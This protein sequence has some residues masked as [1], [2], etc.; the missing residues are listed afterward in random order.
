MSN[1]AVIKLAG[2]QFLVKAG[3][4]F[5]V[6]RVEGEIGSNIETLVIMSTDGEKL[7]MNEG[8]VEV[9]LKDNKRDKK[10]KIVKFRAK[11]RYR[12]AA[13]HRQNISM[14]EV[15]SVNG[16]TKVKKIAKTDSKSTKSKKE[17]ESKEV[18]KKATSAKKSTKK[19]VKKTKKK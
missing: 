8:K 15:V 1:I 10:I 17:V 7:L 9:K 11:S 14:V 4:V 2:S 12:R 16:E 19:V 3:D 13:G 18:E 5:K 6:N